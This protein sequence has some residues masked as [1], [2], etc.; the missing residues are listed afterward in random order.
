M[1]NAR[2]Y[3]IYGPTETSVHNCLGNV[4]VSESIHIG[5]P[6]GNCRYYLLDENRRPLPP[7]AVGEIYIAG[8]CLAA[9]YINREDLTNQVFVPDL[10]CANQRMYKTGDL[11]R[12]RADGNWQCLGRVDNQLKLNGHSIEPEEIASQIIQ[13]RFASEAAV[14][15]VKNNDMVQ[16]LRGFLVPANQYTEEKLRDY[17]MEQLPDYMIP[18]IFIP[19]SALPRTASGKLDIRQLM[20]ME[21]PKENIPKRQPLA[22]PQEALLQSVWE[23]A[24]G[25]KPDWNVSF[26]KQ[27]GTSLTAIMVL[28]QYYKN[29]IDFSLNDFYSCPTL[30]GQIEKITGSRNQIH[31]ETAATVETGAE[32]ERLARFL[33]DNNKAVPK[34][35]ITLLTGA[36]GYLGAHLL[37][38]LLGTGIEKLI[39][40]VRTGGEKKL[41][42]VISSY[43]GESFYSFVSRRIEIVNGDITL[44]HFGI[45]APEYE[46][47]TDR[48][49][50]VIHCAADVR[51]YAPNDELALTNTFGTENCIAFARDAAAAMIH[52]ST[53]SVAGEYIMDAPGL[54]VFYSERDLDMG[55]NWMDNPYTKSKILA[56]A[57]VAEAIEDGVNA[58]IFRV[59][60]LVSR[61][62]DGVFQL[63][64]D[65]NAFYRIIRG[66]LI[67][68]K[69]PR[70]FDRVFMEMTSVDLCAEAIVKL[71]YQPGTAFHVINP[72]ESAL[73][74][75]LKSCCDMELAKR[76]EFEELLRD[77]AAQNSSPFIQ[78]VAEAYFS[79]TAFH[80]QIQIQARDTAYQLQQLGF[81]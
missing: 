53:I 7:T 80:T 40:L 56:E 38:E 54:P 43:F 3:N 22:N 58:R 28:S 70:E 25:K 27:G 63:N 62:K 29:H 81:T 1:T 16:S 37:Y 44:K 60:R 73:R 23:E 59:G 77:Q 76:E 66:L 47:L 57:A 69:I 33:P 31:P 68:K 41:K 18:S 34:S 30:S 52:I 8:E 75:I 2:I 11:G 71:L 20:E 14:V 13:S 45:S 9:G 48:V 49:D 15:P 50:M 79:G 55:Q 39:C 78:A 6:I 65:S 5:K 46:R 74:D 61:A 36:T 19:L 12:L 10:L 64:P 35:R 17:L 26:F 24:L 51:H 72:Q 21:P 4:T 42:E 67:L 32:S